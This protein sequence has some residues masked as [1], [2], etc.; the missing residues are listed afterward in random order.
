MKRLLSLLHLALLTFAAGSQMDAAD[1]PPAPGNA[2][3]YRF[4]AV[5]GDTIVFTA[6]GDLWRVGINGGL[7]QRLTSHP[8]EESHPAFSPDGKTLAFSGQYEGPLEVYTM[9]IDGGRP[10][11]RTFEGG[12]AIVMGWTPDGSKILYATRHFSTLPDFQ[13][14]TVDLKTGV[15]APLPLSQASDGVFEPG[16][17]TLYFTRQWFQGSSTKRYQGGT[18]QNLW[19]FAL[20]AAEAVPLTADF[21]GT[22]KAPMW[23]EGRLYFLSDRDGTMNLW[24]MNPN[25]GDLVQ[26]TKS[27]GWDLKGASLSQGR[28]VYQIGADLRRFDIASK[29]DSL[30][31]ITLASDFDQERE[32]W[33]QKPMDYLSS[34]HVA[35]DGERI[36]LTARGQVF[37]APV[38][39]GRFVNATRDAHIRYRQARF[40]PD[41]KSV[42][43]LSDATGELEFERIPANGVGQAEQ[44]THDGKVFRSDGIAA[45]DGKRIAYQ[46]KNQELWLFDLERKESK[47]IATSRVDGF[48]NLHWSP[49]SQWLAY[50]SSADNLYARISLYGV[51]NGNTVTLT[52]DRVNSFSPAWSPDGK[53][54]YFLSERHLES[55]VASPWGS[56]QPE[57]FFNEPVK[58]YL[59]S[60][61][62]DGRSPFE[63]ADELHPEKKEKKKA[64]Q[65][66]ESKS[67]DN[68]KR[69]E[70][71]KPDAKESKPNEGGNEETNKPPAVVIDMEGL[72]QRVTAVPVPPG[73]YSELS[74]N[75]KALYWIASGIGPT[76]TNRLMTLSVTNDDPK[77][78]TLVE[79]V[80]MYELSEDGKKLLIRK[81][82]QFYVVDAG[83]S[84]P[85]K[86]E[87]SVDL[88]EW[89]YSLDP[90]DE[91]RQMFIESWR[92]M[93]DYFYET[94]MHGIDWRAMRD[95]YLPLVERVTDRAELSDLMA[96]MVG[97]LSALHIFVV[98]GDF[99]EGQDHVS[100]GALGAEL[101][102]DESQNG[103]RVQRIYEADPDYPE[104]RSPL[105]RPSVNLKD[106]A[107]IQMINGVSVLS[108]PHLEA[109]LRNQA[110][111]QVL[112]SVKPSSSDPAREV[113]VTP[114]TLEAETDLRYDDWELSRRRR[115]EELGKGEIGYVHLRAMGPR[116]I[117]EW[118][119]DFYPVFNRKGLIIDVRHNGGGNID[120]WILEKLLRKAWFFWQPRVGNPTWNMQYAFR[121]H[122]TVLC[123][124]HTGSDGEAFTEGFKRLGLGK[125]IGTRTWGGEIWLSFDNRL[126]DK[127]IASAA[128]LGVYGP[129]GKWLIEGHGVD[130]DM[131]V[132]NLPHATFN[133]EDAQLKAAITQLQ[134]RIRL[135]PVTVPPPPAHPNKSV[136]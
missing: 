118:A 32:K 132:D 99:R 53:W 123:D 10:V 56:R 38:N 34:V 48:Y 121:G 100:P 110:G 113:V 2:G 4:P 109:L 6:E 64:E 62:K 115:V 79:P 47:R 35:P 127:G 21:P 84:A 108:A 120:S 128:E 97:E 5:H 61:L 124:E 29:K 58:I 135:E 98:G 125:V 80:K 122:M 13:L 117:A 126:V 22:S 54:L 11:R 72:Q 96:D 9:P 87:K 16:G 44:L 55:T 129:E 116:D 112:L 65:E 8:A 12:A 66:K 1:G 82:D 130:P 57:P 33:M 102:R 43:G 15:T 77:P 36:V 136:K 86:L 63:P 71:S 41:G 133:G 45:P 78:K 81:E 19:K 31:P 17:K 94:N 50:V 119:R 7:A 28:I 104:R 95:K 69:A 14:A 40:M 26:L 68:K 18:V 134:E 93:R 106:G 52:S 60:L 74:V 42:L 67:E 23:W 73:N 88:K 24:S 37:V 59:V 30:I 70:E 92:L 90:R 103:Y 107:I 20:D 25:G 39:Q 85:L 91:R 89:S 75:A 51:T 101:V 105:A 3:Y 27:K 111:R 46:D 49:D 114:M 76:E 83:A 131:V